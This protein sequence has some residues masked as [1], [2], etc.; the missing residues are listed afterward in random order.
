MTAHRI[1]ARDR[2]AGAFKRESVRHDHTRRGRAIGGQRHRRAGSV[3]AALRG[4]AV[5]DE[6]ERASCGAE[7]KC[8]WINH[9][10]YS[11]ARCLMVEEFHE[12]SSERAIPDRC[13]A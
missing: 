2:M 13:N 10:Y 3:E 7:K 4:R 9:C 8:S 12:P 5:Q 1:N 6:K 11:R